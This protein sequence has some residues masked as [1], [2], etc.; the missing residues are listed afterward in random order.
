MGGIVSL[1]PLNV[2]S[3]AQPDPRDAR[4]CAPAAFGK[5]VRVRQALLVTRKSRNIGDTV[6]G[7]LIDV[8]MIELRT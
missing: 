7:I 3:P 2:Q 8:V 5:D 4:S 6:W 1:L